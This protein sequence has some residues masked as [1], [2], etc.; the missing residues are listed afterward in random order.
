MGIAGCFPLVFTGQFTEVQIQWPGLIGK[1]ARLDVQGH[2][3]KERVCIITTNQGAK[4]WGMT[5]GG[6]LSLADAE[7]FVKG[8]KLTD[9]LDPTIGIKK[10]QALPLEIALHDLAGIILD[11]PVYELLGRAQ[12]VLLKMWVNL[13]LPLNLGLG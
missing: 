13:F 4:G 6:Q 7:L 5:R 8:K 1:N 10:E 2:G 3:P 9:V 11:K 12:P